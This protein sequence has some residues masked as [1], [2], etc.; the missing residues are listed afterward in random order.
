MW[1]IAQNVHSSDNNVEECVEEK[2]MTRVA[3]NVF[4]SEQSIREIRTTKTPFHLTVAI[5]SVVINIA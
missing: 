1:E 5:D 2:K 4:K 3:K